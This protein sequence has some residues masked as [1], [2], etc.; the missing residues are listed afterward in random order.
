LPGAGIDD[1]GF[2]VDGSAAVVLHPTQDR[3][4]LRRRDELDRID[5][6]WPAQRANLGSVRAG[7]RGHEGR[8]SCASNRCHNGGMVQSE[9]ER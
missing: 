4:A 1:D 2:V 6:R 5:V 7:G 9:G 8:R 3:A